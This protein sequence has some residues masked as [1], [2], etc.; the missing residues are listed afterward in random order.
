M[1]ETEGLR[2]CLGGQTILAGIDLVV[3]A[4]ESVALVG[5]NGS[6]KTSVLR[7]LLGLVPFSGRARVGGYDVL[8]QAVEARSQMAYIPQKPAF[9]AANVR[10]VV[11]FS[12]AVRRADPARIDRVLEEVGLGGPAL[13]RRA[14]RT[15]SG[16]MQERLSLALA[17]L[18]SAPV[19]LLDEPTASLDREG[20]AAFVETAR[21]LRNDGRTLLLALH[22]S[23]EIAALADRVLCLEGGRVITP[24]TQTSSASRAL[25]AVQG[26]RR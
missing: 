6:G 22:R 8:G 24:A 5:P 16:G 19:M 23:D 3:E 26:G 10:E 15:L 7:C 1:I 25:V 9:G 11:A 18:S 21:A 13:A 20:Q 2:L 12:A 17:L 14:A 4:G